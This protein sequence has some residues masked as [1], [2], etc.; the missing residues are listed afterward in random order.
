M[1]PLLS[2]KWCLSWVC[3]ATCWG[4]HGDYCAPPMLAG[5]WLGALVALLGTCTQPA[6]HRQHSRPPLQHCPCNC[7]QQLCCAQSPRRRC[8]KAIWWLH[9]SGAH[10]GSYHTAPWV[11]SAPP[12][13]RPVEWCLH[14]P[15][16]T[17]C[18]ALGAPWWAELWC[19]VGWLLWQEHP[20]SNNTG[21][22]CALPGAALP[23]A[24]G[25]LLAQQA[26]RWDEWQFHERNTSKTLLVDPPSKYISL[27]I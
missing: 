3:C 8:A 10:H 25:P 12:S 4:P 2:P 7:P 14:K 22:L 21:K 26:S 5:V 27:Y 1:L 24:W 18:A 16:P 17:K 23:G 11:C 6:W 9:Y 15:G 13:V 19:L 20:A